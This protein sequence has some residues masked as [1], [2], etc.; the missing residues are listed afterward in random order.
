MNFLEGLCLTINKPFDFG[1]NQDHDPDPGIINGIFYH[2]G[3]GAGVGI[4]KRL[5]ALRS[6]QSSECF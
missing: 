6:L 5:V 3:I 2:C 1:A 4:L